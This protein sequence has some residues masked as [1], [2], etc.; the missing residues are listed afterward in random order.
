MEDLREVKSVDNQGIY[1][2]NSQTSRF[3]LNYRTRTSIVLIPP[4]K[5]RLRQT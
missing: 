2:G 5:D 3:N 4:F 1:D